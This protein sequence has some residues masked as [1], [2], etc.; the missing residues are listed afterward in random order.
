ML[1]IL[2]VFTENVTKLNV[3]AIDNQYLYYSDR[4]SYISQKDASSH[5]TGSK[6]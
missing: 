5:H 1:T 6:W 4:N 3:A 2:S